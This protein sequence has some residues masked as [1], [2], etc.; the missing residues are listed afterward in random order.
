MSFSLPKIDGIMAYV[1]DARPGAITTVLRGYLNSLY[2]RGDKRSD[3]PGAGTLALLT[4]NTTVQ[5]TSH[6]FL[7]IYRRA[8]SQTSDNYTMGR[9]ISFG[10]VLVSAV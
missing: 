8:P 3:V 1:D 6:L 4:N 2:T 7:G 9:W 5:I 10:I